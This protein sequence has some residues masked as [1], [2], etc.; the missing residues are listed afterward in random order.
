[1]KTAE[2]W[3]GLAADGLLLAFHRL[4]SEVVLGE[5]RWHG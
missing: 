2:T 4:L 5:N 3:E 1:M